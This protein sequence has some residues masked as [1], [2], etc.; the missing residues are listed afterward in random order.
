MLFNGG[1]QWTHLIVKFRNRLD[2]QCICKDKLILKRFAST[3]GVLKCLD[4]VQL[5]LKGKMAL[6]FTFN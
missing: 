5:C 1:S 2:L 4:V 3:D 6:I